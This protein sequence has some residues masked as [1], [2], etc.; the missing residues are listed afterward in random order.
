MIEWIVG[1]VVTALLGALGWVLKDLNKSIK[2]LTIASQ[3]QGESF[4][5]FQVEM[6]GSIHEI[7]ESSRR[8]ERQ[9][10]ENAGTLAEHDTRI[11]KIETEHNL[12]HKQK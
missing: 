12:Y 11:T 8:A 1:G 2:E 5:L 4:K 9:G 6:R 7:R 10:I 3:Q